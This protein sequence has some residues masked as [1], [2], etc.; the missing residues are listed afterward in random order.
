MTRAQIELDKALAIENRAGGRC[1]R[2]VTNPPHSVEYRCAP[3]GGQ[4]VPHEWQQRPSNLV[5]LCAD[6]ILD[7]RASTRLALADGWAVQRPL[8]TRYGSASGWL[9]H[10]L[11]NRWW[12]LDDDGTKTQVFS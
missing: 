8:A 5:A 4:P 10:D 2:C 3:T 6:C 9:V 1:E 11:D 7:V 12:R